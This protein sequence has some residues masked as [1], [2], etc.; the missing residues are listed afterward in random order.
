MPDSDKVLQ[1]QASQRNA[2]P[3]QRFEA[4]SHSEEL[5]QQW[6]FND[7][8]NHLFIPV[9]KFSTRMHKFNQIC[10]KRQIGEAMP[11]RAVN[12]A[13][14]HQ[15]HDKGNAASSQNAEAANGYRSRVTAHHDSERYQVGEDQDCHSKV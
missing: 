10:S 4:D 9:P 15:F 3:I 7:S 12:W 8:H 13:Q 6:Q 5:L 11:Q 1:S 14:V 2:R